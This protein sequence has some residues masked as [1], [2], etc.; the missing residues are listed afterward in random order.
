MRRL[1]LLATVAVAGL[2]LAATVAFA[3]N[4]YLVQA[5]VTP[6]GKGS[7]AKPN[8]VGV[9]FNYQ[10]NDSAGG[11]PAAVKTYK[12]EF[13]GVKSNGKRFPACSTAKIQ[14]AQSGADCP[15]GSKVGSGQV[16]SKV[17]QDAD[18]NDPGQDCLKQLAVYNSGENLATLVLTG[19]GDQCIG[20]AQPFI[21][22]AKFVAG[23]AG[24]AEALSF[25]VPPTVLHPLS[26]LTV[27]VRNVTST[28]SRKRKTITNR[29]TRKK[30]TYGY[31]E[32]TGCL[33][34]SRPIKVTF[35]PEN[36]EPGSASTT[37][38]CT[39]K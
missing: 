9:K 32:S 13:Y 34:S 23:G 2:A 25:D 3:A 19:P 36:G 12:I 21:I 16:Q 10:V 31:F 17:Y 11:K 26:G 28:I 15:A 24:G 29:K 18:P 7:K 39:A 38:R 30:R 1:V 22:P 5:S 37:S 33:G 27:V 8:P 14:A 20:V 35:T 6:S 4:T